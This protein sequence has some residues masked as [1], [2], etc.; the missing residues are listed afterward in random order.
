M[1]KPNN[2][3]I[4]TKEIRKELLDEMMKECDQDENE[5]GRMLVER[6]KNKLKT[7]SE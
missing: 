7:N 1:K 4:L 2:K 5:G 3:D 6:F